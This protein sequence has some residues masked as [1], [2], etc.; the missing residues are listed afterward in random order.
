MAMRQL[1]K[2]WLSSKVVSPSML[3]HRI[4]SAL[5]LRGSLLVLA[6]HCQAYPSYPTLCTVKKFATAAQSFEGSDVTEADFEDLAEALLSS[7][8]GA[9]DKISLQLNP[10]ELSAAYGVL[11]IDLGKRG[12]WVIN[13][14]TPNKQIWWSSPISGPRR[15]AYDVADKKWHWTRDHKVTLGEL[16]TKELT[17]I[18]PGLDF[19]LTV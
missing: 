4:H 7:I 17:T 5:Q 14:Q 19:K 15:F 3:R 16:L 2:R 6:S 8:E 11:T 10:E 9:I 12:T 13:K 18:S 1:A